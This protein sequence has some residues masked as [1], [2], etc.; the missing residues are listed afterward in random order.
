MSL[1]NAGTIRVLHVEDDEFQRVALECTAQAIES[2]VP[3]LVIKLTAVDSAEA[4][5]D[6]TASGAEF[7]LL[8]LDYMLPGGNGDT[9]L[10]KLRERVGQLAAIIMLSGD[11]Q[12]ASMQRCWLDLGADSYRLK[13]ISVDIIQGLFSYTLEKR[14]L[15]QKRRRCG[16]PPS[17]PPED[18]EAT[19]SHHSKR[20]STR[21][22]AA[23]E[24]TPE[25]DLYK[26]DD[27]TDSPPAIVDMLSN[28]R[29]GP[30]HLGFDQRLGHLGEAV[31]MKVYNLESFE[32]GT[33][34]AGYGL[35]PAE[36]PHVNRV[37][38]RLTTGE[39]CVELRE[40]CDGGELFDLLA[41]LGDDEGEWSGA[42]PVCSCHLAF[43]ADAALLRMRPW[44][45]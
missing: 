6:V 31:A 20:P 23:A 10:P 1:A 25:H 44:C 37:L 22:E 15:L 36:H 34:P 17:S 32:V 41:E 11:A 16:S 8:L 28:G 39:Q 29:R 5:L 43:A 40:L 2:S 3:G 30:V 27:S 14:R 12:E 35:P 24:T 18:E 21:R 33:S 13:P 42:Q 19:T 4:A 9:V 26:A 38:S 45:C 7:D